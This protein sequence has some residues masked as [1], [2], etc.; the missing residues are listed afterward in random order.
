MACAHVVERCCGTHST[1]ASCHRFSPTKGCG[2]ESGFSFARWVVRS[3]FW[4]GWQ[5]AV[6]SGPHETTSQQH[7]CRKPGMASFDDLAARLAQKSV[8]DDLIR[9]DVDLVEGVLARQLMNSKQVALFA[10]DGP[11]NGDD[12]NH[13]EYEAP[14]AFWA[15]SYAQVPDFRARRASPAGLAIERRLKELPLDA[16]RAKALFLSVAWSTA[17]GHP[18]RRAAASVWTQLD[19]T[20]R[21]AAIALA[22]VSA[23]QGDA[24]RSLP[25]LPTPR[26]LASSLVELNALVV[27]DSQRQGPWQLR[28]G[29]D[30]ASFEEWK[31][32]HA[33]IEKLLQKVCER[34]ECVETP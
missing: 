27:E 29:F 26:D 32:A 5:W 15:K 30:A 21:L 11:S 33:D 9:I 25:I 28:A 17:Q 22:E 6:H 31:K 34:R 10:G 18:L 14:V 23:H 24:S 3:A 13:L 20:D 16:Q 8:H 2:R 1:F 19:P 12:H 4:W 7:R